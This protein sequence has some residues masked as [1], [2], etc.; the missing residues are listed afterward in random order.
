MTMHHLKFSLLGAFLSVALTTPS[1][2]AS[3]KSDKDAWPAAMKK[4]HAKFTGTK[5]TLAL[6]GDSITVSMAFWSPLAGEPKNMSA[7]MAKAH[8][9][10]KAHMKAD[11]WNK[12]RG[13]GFGNQGSMTIRWAHDNVATWLKKHNPEVAVIMFGTNDLGQVPAK[14]YE[15]KTRAV[16]DQCLKNGTVVILTTIPPRSGRLE[17]SRQFAGIV[18]KIAN[19]RKVPLI[20]YFE[21]TLSRRPDDWDGALPKFKDAP[22]D[23]YQVPTLISRDGVHPSNPS[24]Y[25]DF[26]DESLK[27]NGYGLRSYLTLIAYANVIRQ[28]LAPERKPEDPAAAVQPR[29]FGFP[30]GVGAT[31]GWYV[32]HEF[33]RATWIAKVSHETTGEKYAVRV[34]P[35][36]TTY[37]HLVYGA[38]PDELL[39]GERVNLFFSPD[40]KQQRGFLVHFQDE[41]CQMKG[42]GHSWEVVVAR[43]D[44]RELTARVMAGS[45]PL[46]DKTLSFQVAAQS[47]HWREG[48]PAELPQFRKGDRLYMTWTYRD[49]QRIVHMTADDAS[50]DALK[51]IEQER[52]AGRLAKEGLGAHIEAVKDDKVQLLVF[53]TYWSQAGQWKQGQSLE[54]RASTEGFRP[55]GDPIKGKLTFRKNLG[56]YGSGD[57]EIHVSLDDAAD[58]K[59]L[60]TWVGDKIVRVLGR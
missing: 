3:Q 24:K 58:A 18:R 20:D 28:V 21:E 22:G 9:L 31:R 48:K 35:W 39:T 44:G 49:G 40:E 41:L 43:G 47:R 26:S 19:E 32:W 50:L 12:W 46:D 33:D 60:A 37:R 52:V 7:E 38:H 10:V 1:A 5:G 8:A 17:Q 15:E 16:V 25:R 42:H 27:H 55:T 34:L 54:I 13:P 53:P 51:K 56:T 4:V 11:C 36:A 30:G 23:V 29:R 59:R 57:T 14:E 45:K 6:F 2:A